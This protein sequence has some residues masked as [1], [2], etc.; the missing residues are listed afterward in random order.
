M[1]GIYPPTDR[2]DCNPM[3]P[4]WLSLLVILLVGCISDAALPEV[5]STRIPNTQ[6]SVDLGGPDRDGGYHYY[7][8]SDD[9]WTHRALG[10][11]RREQTAPAKL[12]DLGSGIVRIQWGDAS[13][14]VY[15]IIDC[16]K[17]LIVE[18]SNPSNSKN[19][20]FAKRNE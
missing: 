16:K 4:R 10:P 15:A 11:F 14:A 19:H 9:V 3:K 7:V 8:I 5:S 18:D 1:I 6:F 20:P 13:D 2:S 17:E 12:E